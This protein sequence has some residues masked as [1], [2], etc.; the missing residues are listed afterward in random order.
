M[1]KKISWIK[2]LAVW[3]LLK[4]VKTEKLNLSYFFEISM[5]GDL[6]KNNMKQMKWFL[7]TENHITGLII[8]LTL[9]VIILPHGLQLLLGWFGG[10]GFTSSM[11]FFTSTVG[12]PWIIAFLVIALQSAGAIL[13]LAGLAARVVALAM[14]ILFTGMILTAHLEHGFFMN[15]SGTQKG[16]GFEFHLL[17]ISLAFLLALN[18]AGKYSIDHIVAGSEQNNSVN[19]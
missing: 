16:E 13:I 14:M 12:L 2:N 9:A 18:G 11:N 4:S 17:V 10:N 7:T 1:L 8:R 19:K 3:L 6:L 15:W 5:K